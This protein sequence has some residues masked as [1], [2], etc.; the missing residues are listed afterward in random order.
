MDKKLEKEAML[1]M[2]RAL[3]LK[4]FALIKLICESYAKGEFGDDPEIVAPSVMTFIGGVI[5][6]DISKV[7]K[8]MSS[9]NFEK[10]KSKL[11][12]SKLEMFTGA[13]KKGVF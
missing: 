5:N 4:K 3:D 10:F 2:D 1:L 11:D 6:Q 12:Y 13:V 8:G 9:L 7:K